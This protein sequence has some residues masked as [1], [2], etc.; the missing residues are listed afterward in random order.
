MDIFAELWKAVQQAGPFASMFLL[1]AL[2]AVNAERKAAL[3]K[4]DALVGRFI[5][6][7]GDTQATLK[8]WREVLTKTPDEKKR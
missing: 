6:L 5:E 3:A 7:A 4:Y 2:W 8:D 1:A